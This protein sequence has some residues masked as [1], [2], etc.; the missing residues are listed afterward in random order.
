MSRPT[1]Q[2]RLLFKNYLRTNKVGF[3]GDILSCNF[4]DV[5]LLLINYDNSVQDADEIE[6]VIFDDRENVDFTD[7]LS[8]GTLFYIP[9]QSQD[10]LSVGIGSTSFDIT[11]DDDEL[12]ITYEG[13]SYTLNDQII[14]GN[15]PFNILGVGGVL[16]ETLDELQPPVYSVGVSTTSINEGQSVSF[17][18][19]A[20]NVASGTE[21][22]YTISGD[23][24]SADFTDNTLSGSFTVLDFGSGIPTGTVTKI[25][26]VDLIQE[27]AENFVLQ[28]RTVSTS[29]TVVATSSTITINNTEPTFSVTPSVSTVNEGETVT[30]T[31]STNLAPGTTLYYTLSGNVTS[32]DFVDNVVAGSIT[33]VNISGQSVGTLTKAIRR[34]RTTEGDE[35]FV[36]QLRLN[37]ISGTIVS[38]SSSVTIKDTSRNVGENANGLTFG[39][40]QVNRDNGNV[41]QASDWY[42]ICNL[43]SLP[44]GSKIA[45]FIDG[46]GSMTQS[47]IQASYDLLLSKLAEKNITII[48]VTNPNEDWITPFLTDLN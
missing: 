15:I 26:A 22:F 2:N 16:L 39:P 38:T 47:T 13:T 24:T 45:L 48:T 41:N 25:S 33:L 28:V 35:S 40:V 34:D 27:N 32:S 12:G 29:G 18:I 19:S 36:L 8:T 44:E 42:S 30:F 4:V 1:S 46:S 21:L 7:K 3:S 11:F 31:V 43:D 23:V 10:R 14:L 9:A 20:E 5:K 6:V 37:S 17:T